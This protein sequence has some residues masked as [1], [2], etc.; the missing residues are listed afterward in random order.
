MK[1]YVIKNH[2]HTHVSAPSHTRAKHFIREL[3]TKQC[4]DTMLPLKLFEDFDEID[5]ARTGFHIV[6]VTALSLTY[7]SGVCESG[8]GISLDDQYPQPQP[9][10]ERRET[11]TFF[12]KYKLTVL[13][14]RYHTTR[15]RFESE[16]VY[17]KDVGY[18]IEEVKTHMR[19]AIHAERDI[20]RE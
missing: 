8:F 4:E 19:D 9:I 6:T 10:L 7:Y 1:L 13:P 2:D 16:C 5:A 15:I 18:S 12:R 14:C 20:V 17:T 3:L 11:S